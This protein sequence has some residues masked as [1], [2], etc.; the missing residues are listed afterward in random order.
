MHTEYQNA[1]A[2]TMPNTSIN[3]LPI[4]ALGLCGELAEYYTA[5]PGEDTHSEAGD[6]LWYCHAILTCLRVDANSVLDTLPI[7]YSDDQPLV[8]AGHIAEAVKK[9][10][11]HFKPLDSAGI[12]QNVRR[13]VADVRAHYVHAYPQGPDLLHLYQRNILKLHARY[14]DGFP[15]EAP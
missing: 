5:S 3:H 1:A 15:S 13:I 9:H 14:P 7:V 2:R 4:W 11:G 10:F 8:Y 12:V 6:V